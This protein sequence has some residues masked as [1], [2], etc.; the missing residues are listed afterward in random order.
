M[1]KLLAVSI[2][3]LIS[4]SSLD[5]QPGPEMAVDIPC[6]IKE[7]KLMIHF[8]DRAISE[9]RCHFS[10]SYKNFHFSKIRLTNSFLRTGPGAAFN[11]SPD[12]FQKNQWVMV[13]SAE[14]KWRKVTDLGFTRS[15]WLHEK[16][17]TPVSTQEIF[18]SDLAKYGLEIPLAYF[19]F[20]FPWKHLVTADSIKIPK[21]SKLPVLSYNG[22]KVIVWDQRYK[23][24]H[25]LA[26]RWLK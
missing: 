16:M 21:G 19:S 24:T 8:G 22:N 20:A 17:L 11:L 25:I 15:G 10:L 26:K 2:F 23:R 18:T 9:K 6:L 1:K 14:K 12:A 13:M 4:C 5:R 7:S 3:F